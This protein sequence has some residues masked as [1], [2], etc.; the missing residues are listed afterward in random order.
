MFVMSDAA[1]AFQAKPMAWHRKVCSLFC[2]KSGL[3]ERLRNL[4][5]V[6]VHNVGMDNGCPQ[7]GHWWEASYVCTE[8]GESATGHGGGRAGFETSGAQDKNGQSRN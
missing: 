8:V 2:N 1:A 4:P 7:G 6:R 3:R 5:I